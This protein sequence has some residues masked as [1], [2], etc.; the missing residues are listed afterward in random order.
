VTHRDPPARDRLLHAARAEF[1]RHRRAGARTSRIATRARVNKQLIH[2]YFGTKDELYLVVLRQV[3]DEVA[4]A[5]TGLPLIGLTAVERLRRLARAQFDFFNHNPDHTR[6]LLDAE[7]GAGWAESAIRP[8]ADLLREGQATGFFRDDIDPVT[9]ARQALVL[10]L[11][12]FALR[13][14]TTEWGDPQ[15]WRDRAADLVVRGCTW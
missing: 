1:A 10:H 11:G 4:G 5:L 6:V 2:Y 7:A 8:M 12:Y 3:A 13:P 15:P 14:V 9:Q